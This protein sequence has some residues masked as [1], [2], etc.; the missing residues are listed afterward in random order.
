M[1]DPTDPTDLTDLTA[2]MRQLM[3]FTDTLGV[4]VERYGSMRCGLAWRGMS[5]CVRRAGCCT[6]GS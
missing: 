6:A 1:T 4:S 2:T 3:P 5:A